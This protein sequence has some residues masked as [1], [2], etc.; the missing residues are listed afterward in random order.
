VI[1]RGVVLVVVIAWVSAMATVTVQVLAARRKP[2]PWAVD[3]FPAA[4]ARWVETSVEDHISADGAY[5]PGPDP[6]A[7]SQVVAVVAR[8][9][10]GLRRQLLAV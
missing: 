5:I 10:A 3:W 4:F 7:L 9:V 1:L 2:N 6:E 8:P